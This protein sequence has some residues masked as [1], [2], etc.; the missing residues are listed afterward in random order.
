MAIDPSAPPTKGRQ[1]A[2]TLSNRAPIYGAAGAFAAL[3]AYYFHVPG[4]LVPA[5]Y[6]LI[7]AALSLLRNY[8]KPTERRSENETPPP[9][10]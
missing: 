9:V 1:L 4:E 3:I 8:A 2:G 7:D 6:V 5:V 10:I